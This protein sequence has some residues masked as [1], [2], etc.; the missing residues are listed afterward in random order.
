MSLFAHV[1]DS[2]SCVKAE[3]IGTS[4]SIRN[5]FS[6]QVDVTNSNRTGSYNLTGLNQGRYSAFAQADRGNTGNRVSYSL[7]SDGMG[8]HDK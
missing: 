1:L 2:V 5:V 4:V 3:T 8:A 7:A 6:G